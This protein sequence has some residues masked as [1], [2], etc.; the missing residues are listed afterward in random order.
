MAKDKNRD[1]SAAD[2]TNLSSPYQKDARNPRESNG[3]LP[4]LTP[5]YTVNTLSSN[6]KQVLSSPLSDGSPRS[7]FSMAL[8]SILNRDDGNVADTTA[9]V[10]DDDSGSVDSNIDSPDNMPHR[11][12]NRKPPLACPFFKLNP[13][14]LACS[15]ERFTIIPRLKRHIRQSHEGRIRC[16]R[17]KKRFWSRDDLLTHLRAAQICTLIPET[18]PAAPLDQYDPTD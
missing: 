14:G 4:N 18:Q 5:R 3:Q 17:C 10:N 8:S 1:A 11:R 9:S 13:T 6:A 15:T 16:P 7:A 2:S 12:R